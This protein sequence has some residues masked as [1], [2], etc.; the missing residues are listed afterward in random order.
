MRKSSTKRLVL[1]CFATLFLF[2]SSWSTQ[3]FMLSPANNFHP[4]YLP[5]YEQIKKLKKGTPTA[6]PIQ[7]ELSVMGMEGP[8]HHYILIRYCMPISRESCYTSFYRD[9][10]KDENYF[11]S[12]ILP[13]FSTVWDTQ[14]KPCEDCAPVY[15]L[16]FH[17]E[18]FFESDGC[19][20]TILPADEG[21]LQYLGCS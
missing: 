13:A 1:G 7:E 14:V 18:D 5:L 3:A 2:A 6:E 4:V 9:E 21:V 16:S 8:N 12:V 20:I 15:P 11:G 17:Y 10:I 19:S